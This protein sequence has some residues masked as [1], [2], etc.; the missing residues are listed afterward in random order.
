MGNNNII[1]ARLHGTQCSSVIYFSRVSMPP[2]RIPF[3]SRDRLRTC[4]GRRGVK[5]KL[6]YSYVERAGNNFGSQKKSSV[7]LGNTAAS[8]IC[9]RSNGLSI[10][11]EIGCVPWKQKIRPS[12]V[13]KIR[14]LAPGA[15]FLANSKHVG[16]RYASSRHLS[17]FFA[18]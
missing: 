5:R 17:H 15:P 16:P 4:H 8:L 10:L 9:R 7:T 12:H 11:S 6:Y 2:S 13:N 14:I 3:F 1:C 18:N